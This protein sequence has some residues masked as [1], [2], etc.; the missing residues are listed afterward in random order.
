MHRENCLVGT[1]KRLVAMQPIQI[2][3]FLNQLLVR[4]TKISLK[5]PNWFCWFTVE[6]IK[7]WLEKK[8]VFVG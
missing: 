8:Q 1:I 4:V 6:K 5:Q 3:Y 2:F 7:I